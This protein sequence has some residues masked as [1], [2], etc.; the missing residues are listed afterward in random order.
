LLIIYLEKIGFETT[1]FD[2]IKI[3]IGTAFLLD[4]GFLSH[5]LEFFLQCGYFAR[6]YH[7]DSHI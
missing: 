5:I 6:A 4:T 1:S 3:L 2:F 7:Y